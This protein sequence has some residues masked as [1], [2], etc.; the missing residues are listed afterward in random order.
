MP[1]G[2]LTP[3]FILTRKNR[4]KATIPQGKPCE[5]VSLCFLTT[6]CAVCPRSLTFLI[7]KSWKQKHFV[8]FQ[9]LFIVMLEFYAYNHDFNA[10]YI[11]YDLKFMYLCSHMQLKANT[12]VNGSFVFLFIFLFILQNQNQTFK[13]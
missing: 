4:S 1:L 11:L 13:A 5:D 7:G 6:P 10:I 2:I 8:G 3:S 9:F 12:G